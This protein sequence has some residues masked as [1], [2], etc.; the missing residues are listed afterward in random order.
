MTKTHHCPLLSKGNCRKKEKT[1]TS[2]KFYCSA[3]QTYCDKCK[4][5]HVF[6]K[7]ETCPACGSQGKHPAAS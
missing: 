5:Q 1:P 2:R 7:T 4:K 3:H 6:L